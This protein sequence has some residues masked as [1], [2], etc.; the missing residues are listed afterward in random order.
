MVWLAASASVASLVEA[1]ILNYEKDPDLEKAMYYDSEQNGARRDIADR[2]L[3]EKHY[4]AYLSRATDKA[5]RA[6][7]YVQ[8]GVL[9]ATNWHAEK[10]EEPDYPKA[11]QYMRKALAE[12][13]NG[14][15][16][17]M[18]RARSF[19]IT[20]D[21]SA[22]ERLDIRIDNYKWF[23]AFDDQAIRA[24]WL[25]RRPPP[26]KE[27]LADLPPGFNMPTEPT[28][29]QLSIF[30]RNLENF[31]QAEDTNLI[32]DALRTKTPLKSLRRIVDELPGTKAAELAQAKLDG[33][34][35]D[36][37]D[38]ALDEQIDALN[39]VP[40][41]DVAPPPDAAGPEPS[42]DLTA[43]AE[44]PAPASHDD[45]THRAEDRHS[46]PLILAGIGGA[47]GIAV[48]A[49]LVGRRRRV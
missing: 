29:R 10:G 40:V 5:H 47:V 45:P 36:T 21:Q 19:L 6:R 27:Q 4:L 32:G 12:L 24:N 34:T 20:P 48:V 35:H 26:T 18:V 28:P 17:E 41:T 2:A 42:A 15:S 11:R 43:S 13:P 31:R 9:Y 46:Q 3:A 49:M 16:R 38:R 14:I 8:L 37:A 39:V 30:K 1:R 33:L 25:H 44:L 23:S 22:P 7:V